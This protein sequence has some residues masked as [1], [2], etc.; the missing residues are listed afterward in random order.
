MYIRKKHIAIV[1]LSLPDN[2]YNNRE[3]NTCIYNQGTNKIHK[4]TNKQT[5]S[6]SQITL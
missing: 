6:E 2:S 1:T 5:K 4:Q 3:V